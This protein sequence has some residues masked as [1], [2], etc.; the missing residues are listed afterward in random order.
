MFYFGTNQ[1]LRLLATLEDWFCGNTIKV[2][3][4]IFY[5]FY[6]THAR[7]CERVLPCMYAL[8][9]NKQEECQMGNGPSTMILDLEKA[10]LNA[11]R[12]TLN[13]RNNVDVSGCFFSFSSNLWNHI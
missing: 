4:R 8:L 13:T 2:C 3:P 1:A 7:V 12:N 6:M 5:Q 11:T 10:A 9:P